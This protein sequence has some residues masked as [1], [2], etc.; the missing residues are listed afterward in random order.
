MTH[1]NQRGS[2]LF[3]CTAAVMLLSCCQMT[4]VTVCMSP[5]YPVMLSCCDVTKVLKRR[6]T[7]MFIITEKAL[8]RAFSWFTFKT[9]LRHY[10]M[11]NGH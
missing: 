1:D 8:I 5:C 4:D 10:T 9:L 11:L 7:R 3:D 6:S 2:H